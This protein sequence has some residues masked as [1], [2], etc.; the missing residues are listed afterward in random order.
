MLVSILNKT[1]KMVRD[2][3]C[4]IITLV[5]LYPHVYVSS[6]ELNFYFYVGLPV[7]SSFPSF[8]LQTSLST[9]PPSFSLSFVSSRFP[10]TYVNWTRD[11]VPIE[12]NDEGDA[13][14]SIQV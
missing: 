9:F 2:E 6:F 8:T 4:G 10:P 12:I 11:G 7:I 5:A 3:C 14:Q 13:Y 1:T